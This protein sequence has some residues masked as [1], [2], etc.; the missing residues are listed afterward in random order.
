MEAIQVLTPEQKSQV[1]KQR[2]I[3]AE[4]YVKGE[5][6]YERTKFRDWLG[7]DLDSFAAARLHLD[8]GHMV[9]VCGCTEAGVILHAIKLISDA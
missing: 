5:A 4:N 1:H 9:T 3:K 7:N 8:L 2:L 6:G